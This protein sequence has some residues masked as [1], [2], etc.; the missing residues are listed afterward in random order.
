MDKPLRYYRLP[1]TCIKKL[2]SYVITENYLHHGVQKHVADLASETSVLY[3]EE[4]QYTDSYIF[5]A[6]ADNR[7]CGSIRI[8][9]KLPGQVMPIEKIYGIDISAL[10]SDCASV[11][12]IGRFAVTKGADSSGIRIFKTLM[13]LALNVADKNLAGMVFAECDH[14]LLRIVRQLGIDAEAIGRPVH[15]LGS[16]TVPVQMTWA[17]FQKFLNANTELLCDEVRLWK[18]PFEVPVL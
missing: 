6:I 10:V 7:I 1:L 17:S 18:N 5:A 8:C 4:A 12:H 13:A 9:K 11:Y 2:V 16:E 14:K 15:Y 3:A